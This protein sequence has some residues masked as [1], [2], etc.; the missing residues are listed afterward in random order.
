MHGIFFDEL[1]HE[2]AKLFQS[3]DGTTFLLQQFQRNLPARF[4]AAVLSCEFIDSPFERFSQTK[5]VAMQ[6]QDV[7][8]PDGIEH[9]VL[10]FDFDFLHLPITGLA[11]NAGAFNQAERLKHFL[12]A[13]DD[14]RTDPSSGQSFE[15]GFEGFISL[16]IRHAIRRL[17]QIQR[18]EANHL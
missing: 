16:A 1:R 9:P 15:R 7:I 13:G 17:Q 11:D 4:S 2:S 12:S 18:F 6:R 10:K 5:I 3:R 8:V 14:N